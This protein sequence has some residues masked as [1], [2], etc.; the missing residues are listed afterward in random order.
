MKIA[1]RL[2]VLV[3]VLAADGFIA[4]AQEGKPVPPGAE[5]FQK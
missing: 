2:S 5:L 1:A 4:T 3:W